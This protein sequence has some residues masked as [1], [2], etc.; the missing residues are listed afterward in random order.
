MKLSDIGWTD[1]C[2]RRF[3]KKVQKSEDGCW[4]WLPGLKSKYRYGSFGVGNEKTYRIN[5]LSYM[6][7]HGSVPD[8]MSVC[9]ECDN[10]KCVRPSHLFLGD[11]D[12]NMKDM[13]SKG[14][15]AQHAGEENG[16]AKL[17]PG[18]VV[19]I[20]I[21]AAAGETHVSLALEYGVDPVT[22]GSIVHGKLWACT[23]GPRIAAK[24]LLRLLTFDGRTQS[25]TDWSREL[26]VSYAAL[27][28]RLELGWS[29]E[30]ALSEPFRVMKKAA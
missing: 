1:A 19:Q 4:L 29:V 20:R 22:I 26:G 3:W 25:M 8:D 23:G 7:E 21:R 27:G 24:P 14:R 30:R 15:S 5:R 6:I 16:R 12:V 2:A 28:K 18:Q 9:H 13:V 11:Q 10:D 17:T